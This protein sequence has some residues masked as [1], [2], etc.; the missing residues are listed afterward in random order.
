MSA[1]WGLCAFA[2][3][4][5]GL[6]RRSRALRLAALA[7]FGLVLAKIFTYDLAG[8]SSL[9]RAVSFLAVGGLLLLAAFLYE[10]LSERREE[11]R[12]AAET[13]GP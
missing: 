4:A 10:R 12:L 3:L 8:L 5:L 7:L 11:R 2:L 9:A 1:L 13:S 6:A